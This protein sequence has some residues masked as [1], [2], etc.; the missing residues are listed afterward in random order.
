MAQRAGTPGSATDAEEATLETSLARVA[1]AT[2]GTAA[3]ATGDTM[4]TPDPSS[5]TGVAVTVVGADG[6][7]M[8]AAAAF[9]AREAD[10]VTTATTGV[11]TDV[12]KLLAAPD[13][14]SQN[15]TV[16]S[17]STRIRGGDSQMATRSRTYPKTYGSQTLGGVMAVDQSEADF[18]DEEAE[19][20][21]VYTIMQKQGVFGKNNDEP[22]FY[23]HYADRESKNAARRAFGP[24]CLNCGDDT[25][26]SRNCPAAYINRS[27]I[28]HP[29][30]GEGTPAE[31]MT[32][33]RR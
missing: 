27:N 16:A 15:Q 26:F 2:G 18:E 3:I 6:G 1:D 4:V 23:I 10:I 30:V 5:K 22:P 12:D 24:R 19:F 14:L 17:R 29:A 8:G 20:R 21:K 25:H 9:T 31:V 11:V 7:I 32:R 33:W 13:D 28:F